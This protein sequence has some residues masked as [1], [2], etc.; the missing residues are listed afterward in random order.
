MEELTYALEA[1]T[2]E[3]KLLD[4]KNIT[5]SE[6]L[7]KERARNKNLVWALKSRVEEIKRV[8]NE[9]DLCKKLLQG[10]LAILKHELEQK[11]L[12][13]LDF[14]KRNERSNVKYYQEKDGLASRL[15]KTQMQL[16][17][18]NAQNAKLLTEVAD[19]KTNLREIGSE[20]EA[21]RH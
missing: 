3:A 18:A 4:H 1:K 10:E 13:I 16:E 7:E 6:R 9:T 11:C 2:R 20:V 5:L 15:Q 19:Q 8:R 12:F 21:L 17:S 14:A